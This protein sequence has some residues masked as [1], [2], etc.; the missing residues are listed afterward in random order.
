MEELLLILNIKTCLFWW[1]EVNRG[2]FNNCEDGFCV[3]WF[4]FGGFTKNA[5]EFVA[6]EVSFNADSV[7]FFTESNAFTHFVGEVIVEGVEEAVEWDVVVIFVVGLFERL[8]FGE[9]G[10]DLFAITFDEFGDAVVEW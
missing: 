3:F 1:K 4:V 5:A 2:S 10:D 7:H 6:E 8:E 9:E